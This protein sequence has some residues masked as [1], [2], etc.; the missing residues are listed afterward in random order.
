VTPPGL[1]ALP[2]AMTAPDTL[3]RVLRATGRLQITQIHR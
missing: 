3:L 1:G 2:A